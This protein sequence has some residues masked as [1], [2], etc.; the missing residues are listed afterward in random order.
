MLKVERI[1]VAKKKH[2]T[3]QNVHNYHENENDSQSHNEVER[4]LMMR[5]E[6]ESSCDLN[7]RVSISQTQLLTLNYV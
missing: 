3:Y 2:E 6:L 5:R 1:C 7:H 4:I